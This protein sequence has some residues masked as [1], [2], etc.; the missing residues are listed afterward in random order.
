MRKTFLQFIFWLLAG[1]AL[2]AQ[3]AEKIINPFHDRYYD[4]LK[5]MDYPYTFPILG[6]GAYKRGYDIP[7][8]WG[9]S[10]VYFTQRQQIAITSTQ[11]GVNGSEKVDLSDFIKFGPVIAQ[12]NAY[13]VRPDLWV[14]PFLNVYGVFGGGTTQTDVLLVEPAI[15]QTTQRFNVRSAGVGATLA[16][17]L[18]GV[19]IVW[20]NNINWADVDALVE[21]VPAFNSSVRVGHN[22]VDPRHADRNLS[23]W[24]GTFYQ[25]INN[26]TKGSIG[27]N[28]VF[29]G[30]GEGNVIAEMRDWASGL[31]PAQRVIANQIIDALENA[32]GN[33]PDDTQ[34]DY[35]LDKKVV[36]PFNLIFG[37]QFQVN[38]HWQFRTELGVFGKR[39]QFLLNANYR[40]QGFRRKK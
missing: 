28:E 23:I 36:G 12:T 3:Y 39:S 17:G 22:F 15:F 31:P 19:F 20:D 10:A 33:I 13:T 34:I 21:P 6:K 27:V 35:F 16:G 32:A 2:H 9:I 7:F 1:Q 30:F 37:A 25:K 14:L 38:K 4:S 26:D 5:K 11:I 40:F 8:P 29:P 18:G 24:A